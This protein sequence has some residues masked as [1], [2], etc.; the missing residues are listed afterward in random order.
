MQIIVPKATPPRSQMT[1]CQ[2][3]TPLCFFCQSSTSIP[4]MAAD[5]AAAHNGMN[6]ANTRSSNAHDS[7]WS[8]P[9]RRIQFHNFFK[10]FI[11][12]ILLLFYVV[13]LH[14]PFRQACGRGT[15][16]RS[17]CCNVMRLPARSTPKGCR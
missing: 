7:P 13:P 10:N 3:A 16:I 12:S 1:S 6:S 11:P 4:M 2:L 8:N 17:K 15:T 5:T 14:A 9:S